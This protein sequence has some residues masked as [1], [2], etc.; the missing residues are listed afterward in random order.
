[1]SFGKMSAQMLGSFNRLLELAIADLLRRELLQTRHTVGMLLD[2]RGERVGVGIRRQLWLVPPGFDCERLGSLAGK[3]GEVG[4]ESIERLGVD[5]ERFVDVFAVAE[6][7]QQRPQFVH[8]ESLD[9]V[10]HDERRFE[11]REL[12]MDGRLR[13]EKRRAELADGRHLTIQNELAKLR[14]HRLA[15]GRV[16]PGAPRTRKCLR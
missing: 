13:R 8:A 7:S 4:I 5:D 15:P 10:L 1:M 12:Q 14:V 9:E 3:V 16:R 11:I 2:P 6:V